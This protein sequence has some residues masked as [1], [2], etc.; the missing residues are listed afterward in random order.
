MPDGIDPVAAMALACAG[1]TMVHALRERRPVRLGDT[2]VVQGSG[3]VGLAAAALAQLAGARHVI[4]VGGPAARLRAAEAAGIGHAHVDIVAAEDPDSAIEA[5]LAQTPLSRGADLVVECTGVPAAIAQGVRMARRNGSYLVVGHYTDA[6]DCTVNPHEI[7]RRQL[8]VTGSWAFSGA[9]L[10]EYIRL[11]PRLL[12]SF[13]LASLVT[14]FP[15]ERANEAL[16]R[17]RSGSVMKAVLS[18]SGAPA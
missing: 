16:T 2:V 7:V 10:F 15:L 12:D 18:T 14:E 6:G 9:H 3:P 1:P 8:D 5:V 13:D 11:L 17:L 4:V